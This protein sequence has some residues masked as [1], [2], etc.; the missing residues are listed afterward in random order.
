MLTGLLR[1]LLRDDLAQQG[2]PKALRFLNSGALKHSYASRY[3]SIAC[4]NALVPSALLEFREAHEV[5]AWQ[6]LLLSLCFCCDAPGALSCSRQAIET[7]RMAAQAAAQMC[8]G[9]SAASAPKQGRVNV[10]QAVCFRSGAPVVRLLHR[11]K[12]H[13][14]EQVSLLCL[15]QCRWLVRM[16]RGQPSCECSTK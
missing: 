13:R 6:L 15:V 11:A 8:T 1:P 14:H 5:P 4:R 10:Q 3:A 12:L 7:R 16:K 9:L 2:I